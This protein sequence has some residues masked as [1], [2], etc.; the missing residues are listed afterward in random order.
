MVRRSPLRNSRWQV[1]VRHLQRQTRFAPIAIRTV[2]KPEMVERM[3]TTTVFNF[4]AR[5][6][7]PHDY[8]DDLH[9]E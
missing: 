1:P 3:K 8:A 4:R 9:G 6:V 5:G 2:D 7:D